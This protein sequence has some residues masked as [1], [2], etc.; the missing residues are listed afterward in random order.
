M[1][2]IKVSNSRSST[3]QGAA[4]SSRASGRLS[5]PAEIS[6]SSSLHS[7]RQPAADDMQTRPDDDGRRWA[8]RST[9]LLSGGVSLLIWGAIACV[10]AAIR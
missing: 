5:D 9:L 6:A 7:L 1:Q 2:K 10:A 8:P 3:A 4:L